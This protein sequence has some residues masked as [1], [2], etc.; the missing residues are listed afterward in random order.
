MILIAIL[1]VLSG[2]PVI[3]SH[4][5]PGFQGRMFRLHK[6]RTMSKDDQQLFWYSQLLR[7]S[8]LDE[9]PQLF[10]ILRGEMSFIGPRPLLREYLESYSIDQMRRHAVKPGITG[11]AQVHGRN[12]LNL[13]DKIRYDLYYVD[14][15][16]F[17]L[18]LLIVLKTCLQLFKW[19]ES[20]YH[21][22]RPQTII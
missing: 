8:S 2:N 22:I 13:D 16:S 20:D 9:L 12:A 1:I 15:Q 4:E 19:R 3:F 11:W 17:R 18:D 10:N 6:F 21:S 5:R 7:K 14:R